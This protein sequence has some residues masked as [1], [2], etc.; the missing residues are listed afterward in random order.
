MLGVWPLERSRGR[1]APHPDHVPL[2][3][4]E[5]LNDLEQANN[6]AHLFPGWPDFNRRPLDP[7]KP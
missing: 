7:P 1:D 5:R 4:N 6:E 3:E 2:D